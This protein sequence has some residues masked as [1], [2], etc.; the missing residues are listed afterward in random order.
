MSMGRLEGESL[1]NYTAVTT[2]VRVMRADRETPVD[3]PGEANVQRVKR[4][5]EE[6]QKSGAVSARA[7]EELVRVAVLEAWRRN[8]SPTR[9]PPTN[10]PS[11]S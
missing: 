10:S 2:F 9:L 1:V 6:Y 8:C 7:I 5:W 4:W 11:C 3:A